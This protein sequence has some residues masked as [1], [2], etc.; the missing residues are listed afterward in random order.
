MMNVTTQPKLNDIHLEDWVLQAKSGD[1]QAFTKLMERTQG[2]A[3]KTAFPLLRPH[4]VDDAVQEAFIVVFKKLQ[5]L[6]DPKA[7]QGWL[8]RI[9]I[10]VCH[11]IRKK[12]PLTTED[13]EDGSSKEGLSDQ[14]DTQMILRE[15]LNQLSED[16]RNVLIL[17]EFIGFDY[18]EIS[19]TL[20]LPVGTVR[21]RLHYGR[22]KLAKILSSCGQ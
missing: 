20:K 6:R 14:V 5:H 18:E 17:R 4:Q 3:R 19:Y 16:S 15:A 7:F 12:T 13:V 2:L 8:C 10:N 21:S 11:A 9:V 1:K 22:K